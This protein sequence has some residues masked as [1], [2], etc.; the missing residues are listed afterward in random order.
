MT[1]TGR[2][3]FIGESLGC[4]RLLGFLLGLLPDA[5]A[6]EPMTSQLLRTAEILVALNNLGQ[7]TPEEIET[8]IENFDAEDEIRALRV[9]ENLKQEVSWS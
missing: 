6:A 4:E 2:A 9:A 5:L 8:E 7:A 1:V 3:G